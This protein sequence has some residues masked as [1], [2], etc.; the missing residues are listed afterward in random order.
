MKSRIGPQSAAATCSATPFLQGRGGVT[1]CQVRGEIDDFS[2][3]RELIQSAVATWCFLKIERETQHLLEAEVR[4]LL[5][6]HDGV[7]EEQAANALIARLE[8]KELLNRMRR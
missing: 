1:Q 2:V 7:T 4:R 3:L 6:F 8:T 5:D